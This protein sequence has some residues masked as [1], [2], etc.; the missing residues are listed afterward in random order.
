M[1]TAITAHTP[2]AD[3]NEIAA[4]GLVKPPRTKR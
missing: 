2:D 3:H 1:A 4:C